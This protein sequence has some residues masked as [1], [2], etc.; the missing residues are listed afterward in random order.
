MCSC[1]YP[2]HITITVVN[3]FAATEKIRKEGQ[4][5]LITVLLL[6]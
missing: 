3:I 5:I 6:L 1:T 4:H 2:Y